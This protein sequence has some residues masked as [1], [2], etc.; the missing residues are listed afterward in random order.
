MKKI[1]LDESLRDLVLEYE[2]RAFESDGLYQQ[3]VFL[4]Y[5]NQLDINVFNDLFLQ[6]QESLAASWLYFHL[7]LY[8]AHINVNSFIKYQLDANNNMLILED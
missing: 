6:Y 3:V 5:E 2:Q 8:I 7:I 1:K 4:L